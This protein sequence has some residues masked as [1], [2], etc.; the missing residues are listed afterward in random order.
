MNF[1]ED[2]IT[3]LNG[4][5]LVCLP[6]QE[7]P[8]V[9]DEDFLRIDTSGQYLIVGNRKRS[10]KRQDIKHEKVEDKESENL[11]FFLDHAFYFY[12]NADRI[13]RDSR[14]FLSPVPTCCGL[15][16]TGTSGFK[17]PTLGIYIEWW[18][19]VNGPAT[20]DMEENDALTYHIAGSPLSGMNTCRCVYPDGITKSISHHPFSRIWRSFIDINTRYTEAKQ[21]YEAYTL[22][23]VWELLSKK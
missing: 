9:I 1:S 19:N 5:E 4:R 11:R 12:E 14:M 6:K 20:K 15:A 3:L 10:Q 22:Q 17:N 7:Q 13:L 21:R 16:Y 18:T 8:D 23:E 2:R